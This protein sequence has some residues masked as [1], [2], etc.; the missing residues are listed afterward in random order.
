MIGKDG[1]STGG[2]RLLRFPMSHLAPDGKPPK[3]AQGIGA[4]HGFYRLIHKVTCRQSFSAGIEVWQEEDGDDR[5]EKRREKPRSAAVSF[6]VHGGPPFP[7]GA[8][9]GLSAAAVLIS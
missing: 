3:S 2:I 9:K 1:R 7:D 4:S 5:R 6:P 8:R